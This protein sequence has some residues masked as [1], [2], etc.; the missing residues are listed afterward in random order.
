MRECPLNGRLVTIRIFGVTSNGNSV[1][2]KVNNFLPYFYVAAPQDWCPEQT[3]RFANALDAA[4]MEDARMVKDV[5]LR[6]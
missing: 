3:E 6:L 1:C 5:K 2:I 4:I